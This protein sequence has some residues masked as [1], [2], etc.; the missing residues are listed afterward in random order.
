MGNHARG[1][2]S[3]GLG[4]TG[5]TLPERDKERPTSFQLSQGSMLGCGRVV[6]G[7]GNNS[8]RRVEA[9]G[10]TLPTGARDQNI[11]SLDPAHHSD[12]SISGLKHHH[13]CT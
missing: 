6:Q 8:Q 13:L 7:H 10:A 4:G 3:S 5:L 2:L 11:R 1:V 9:L 12:D